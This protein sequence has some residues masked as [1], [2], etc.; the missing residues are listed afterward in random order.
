MRSVEVG[1]VLA[2]ILSSLPISERASKLHVV[3]GDTALRSTEVVGEVIAGETAAVAVVAL[4][5]VA[6]VVVER[7][8]VVERQW[9][10][11]LSLTI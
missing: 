6:V 3:E 4:V 2:I 8:G 10:R 5:A 11:F 7:A 9:R 1:V